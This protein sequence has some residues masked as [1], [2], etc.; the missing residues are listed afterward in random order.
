MS[1]EKF[2]I[3]EI[4]KK[5]NISPIVLSLME[6]RGVDSE[7]KL[8]C[9]LN[10]TDKS[11]HDP[12]LLKG[13][14]EL[15][16]R[17]K[18]AMDNNEKVLI[19]G[20]YDVDGVSA[21]AIL[22]KYFAEK[23]F[24]VDY[25][26]P[27]R[28]IDGYGLTKDSILRVKDKFNPSL[29]ITVDCGI[30]CFEEVEF[31][32]ALGIDIVITDHHDIPEV[33]PYTIVVDPKMDGQDYPFKSL[34]GTGVAFKVVQA[35][36]GLEEAKKYLGIAA[37]A[38]IADIVPLEDENRA[39]VKLGMQSFDKTLPLGLKMLFEENKMQLDS[40]ATDIAYKLS[41]KINAAGRM[42]DAS[43]ALKLYIK[44]D[45]LLLKNTIKTLGDMN[46]ER[47]AICNRIY[48][49]V[50]NKLAQI[51]I[52][53]YKSIVLYSKKW[54]SGVLGIVAAKIAG[55]Y[56]R[57]TILLSDMGEELK[58]SARSI[59][60]IDIFSAIS[61]TKE[62]LE[63]FGGHKMAAGLTIRKKQF[64]DFLSSLNNYLD[65]N[66][67]SDD[68][69][70]C[71]KF[72]MELKFDQINDK[73]MADLDL[74]EPCGCG[75]PKPIFKLYLSDR[76][77]FSTMP[78]HPN[79][80]TIFNKNL[81][82]IAFN[83][84]KYLPLLK[85]SS[86][87]SV[88]LELQNSNFRGKK[89]YKGIAKDISTGKLLKPKSDD[90]LLGEYLKQLSYGTSGTKNPQLWD[91]NKLKQL[92]NQAKSDAFGTL[93]VSY[94]F[95]AYREFCIE[96]SDL[97]LSHC[98]YEVIKNSGINSIVLCPTNFENFGSYKR[99]IFLDEV[100][101][102]GFLKEI[103]KHS[104]ATIYVPADKKI[105]RKLFAGLSTDRNDFAK[106]FK[107]LSDFASRQDSFLSDISL[108]KQLQSKDKS[109]NFKQFIFCLY[110]FLEL[111]IFEMQDDLG[112]KSLKEDKKVVSPLTNSQFY[113]EVC[114]ILKT[115]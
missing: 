36:S 34:C 95:G 19:F 67:S 115:V 100:L 3:E 102:L 54:D 28:Y 68:F 20:D 4:A 51:N 78:K 91:K 76:A 38:T 111:K 49:D 7:E 80:L 90:I 35:L 105:D 21:S 84:Y 93:F 114:M 74:I 58:G 81:N 110:V 46:T 42:G 44:D 18:K 31:A 27:N 69:L 25:F 32:K 41:P 70:P 104:G 56:N 16:A 10:P 55:E 53:N 1:N 101:S 14:K 48:D 113:N 64:N 60:D 106:Y 89:Y 9:F 45:K 87:R 8:K 50:V 112:L 13:M 94:S 88:Q 22:I 24:Y 40:S 2:E 37:I 39:I 77:T 6:R 83:S 59:N 61:C 103:S 5:Y 26:L 92:A 98:L 71:E 85:A 107:L 99:I 96:N 33:L 66:Y 23:N 11:F 108:F 97:V 109:I 15:V 47:Q 86:D 30:S 57:P 43:V 79:H 63:T 82:I 73:F 75:N 17:I 72:D 62:T 52:A 65:K 29:I 12:F